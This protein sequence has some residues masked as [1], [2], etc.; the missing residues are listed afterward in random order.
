MNCFR[1]DRCSR[2]QTLCTGLH[3]TDQ[4]QCSADKNSQRWQLALKLM[5]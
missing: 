4:S 3:H 5:S 1:V 2:D